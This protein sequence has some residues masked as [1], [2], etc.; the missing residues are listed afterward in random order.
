MVR[1]ETVSSLA[2]IYLQGAHVTH[3]QRHGENPILFL[4]RE[5]VFAAGKPIRGGVPLILP[6]FGPR[7]GSSAHGFARNENWELSEVGFS[8]DEFARL[9]FRLPEVRATADWPR[10][11]AEFE[12][13]IGHTLEMEL[14]VTNV[15]DA[16]ELPLETCLHTYFAVSDI[17]QT[18]VR[19][20]Q[21]VKYLDALDNYREKV[22]SP[23]AICVGSE[24]DRV[25]FNSPETVEIHDAA[26][27]RV[28]EVDKSD[29]LSTVVWNP[30]IEKSKRLAD[31]GD[32]EYLRMICIESGNIRQNSHRLKPGESATLAVAIDTRDL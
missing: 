10:F 1:V 30:W 14:K 25:Y 2:E 8:G 19:G 12:V 32:D 21:G 9:R 15:D 11:V 26:W 17:T 27:G 5:A 22:E 31:F 29:S 18:T 24:V 4:S 7:E 23:E 20:L 28:I 13:L 3:F 16:R 6:W